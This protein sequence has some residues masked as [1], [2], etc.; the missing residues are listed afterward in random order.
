MKAK[1]LVLF[2]TAFVGLTSCDGFLDIDPTDKATEKIVWSRAEYARMAVNNFYEG[3]PR[4]GSYNNYQCLAGMT[5][6]LT[7]EFKYGNMNYNAEN[8]IPNEISYGGMVLTASYVDVY[9]GI[10]ESTYEY[11][12]RVNEALSRLNASSLDSVTTKQLSGE[13]HFFRGMYYFELLK[14]YHQAILYT[15]DLSQINTNKAMGSEEDCWTFVYN[16]LK[17]AGEHLSVSNSPTGRLTS[18]AAYALM[19]RAMLYCQNWNAVKEACEKVI[20]MGYTLTANYADAFTSGNSEAI[21]QYS[22]SVAGNVTHNFDGYYAPGGDHTLAGNTMYGGFATPTQE[23]I[24]E[25]ELKTG[26]K[27]DWSTW[28]TTDGT[29]Q[30]PPY[31]QLE[32]RFH[33]TILYNKSIWKERTIEPYIGGADG[34]CTWQVD[35]QT[36]GRTTTGYYLRKLVD[37]KHY[38]AT[39]Q[40]SSQPW[41]AF[42]LGEVYLN[43]AEACF[44]LN[45][46]TNAMKYINLVRTR[47]G[48]PEIKGQSGEQLF[49]SLRHERKVELAFEGLYYWDMRRWGLST[50]ELTGIRRHGLKIIK[51]DDGTFT[52]S[53]VEVDNQNLDYPAKMNR[54][55][56]PLKEIENNREIEQFAEWK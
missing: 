24:E 45:D 27:A 21:F 1:Y 30:E 44:R 43:Y 42:R 37:E 35:P 56:I 4:L 11:I 50:S 23:M 16:D 12:R 49:Q 34:W 31:D 48:L 38:F 5:E 10:W 9:M 3:I 17:Y 46:N 15:E 7:D 18:G 54:F 52:Y 2:I 55:P 28:H 25:Y 47:V 40:S 53:Y 13:L 20:A 22:Y 36:E 51:N 33:A 41:I 32:P 8:Y 6:G 39:Q 26:G 14:R 19:S 29:T